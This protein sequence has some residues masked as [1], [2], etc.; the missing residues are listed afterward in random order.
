M[1]ADRQAL[2][3]SHIYT[4]T[5]W[6]AIRSSNTL[7]NENWAIFSSTSPGIVSRNR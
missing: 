4:D 5:Q 1:R 2:R 6:T 7:G 3:T